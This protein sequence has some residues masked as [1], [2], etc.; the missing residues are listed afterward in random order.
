MIQIRKVTNYIGVTSTFT[1]SALQNMTPIWNN[2]AKII[3]M[4]D[5]MIY[6]YEDQKCPQYPN[7][8]GVLLL[9]FY[10]K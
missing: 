1:F 8:S 6:F 2:L 9:F 10:H 5:H 4:R 7:L 3:L